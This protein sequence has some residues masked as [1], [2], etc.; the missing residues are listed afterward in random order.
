MIAHAS[1]GRA[2]SVAW[3][4]ARARADRASNARPHRYNAIVLAVLISI[5]VMPAGLRGTLG[6]IAEEAEAA[7]TEAIVETAEGLADGPTGGVH[8]AYYCLQTRS[9]AHYAIHGALLERVIAA[10]CKIID[11]RSFHPNDHLGAAHVVHEMCKCCARPS[12]RIAVGARLRR[13]S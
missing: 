11:F 1:P 8:P 10:N 3:P 4:V 6:R 7:I 12:R 5:V 2:C 9:H 13:S